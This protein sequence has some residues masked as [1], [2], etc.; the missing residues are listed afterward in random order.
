[1]L[2]AKA[3]LERRPG[4]TAG[5]VICTPPAPLPLALLPLQVAAAL[6]TF[7]HDNLCAAR[8]IDHPLLIG[9][10]K[11]DLRLYVLVRCAAKRG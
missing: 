10:L 8:Y 6:P 3:G 4:W 9:G 5:A 7:E 1:M 2:L 11:F